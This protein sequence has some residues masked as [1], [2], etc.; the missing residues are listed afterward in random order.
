MKQPWPFLRY[1][2]ENLCGGTE[3]NYDKLKKKASFWTGNGIRDKP[4]MK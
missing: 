1:S 3:R 2:L 4:D